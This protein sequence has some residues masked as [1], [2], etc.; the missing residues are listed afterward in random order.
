MPRGAQPTQKQSSTLPAQT[1][2]W[3]CA[4][5]LHNQKHERVLPH[6]QQAAAWN[7]PLA[8]CNGFPTA[9]LTWTNYAIQPKRCG[10]TLAPVQHICRLLYQRIVQNRNTHCV[11]AA[12]NVTHCVTAAMNVTH[13]VTAAMKV[14]HCVTAAMNVTHC[15]TAAMN[16]T[17]CVTAAMN[18]CPTATLQTQWEVMA[19]ATARP[20]AARV[21]PDECRLG[22]VLQDQEV[23]CM[24]YLCQSAR[25]VLTAKMVRGLAVDSNSATKQTPGCLW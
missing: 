1:C 6:V 24:F 23:G 8:V 2:K 19:A 5:P 22:C 17:H 3:G 12:M 15:V 21:R 4:E 13:C 9:S 10:I 20:A 7:Q 11:T 25:A 18:V 14:T 16:V